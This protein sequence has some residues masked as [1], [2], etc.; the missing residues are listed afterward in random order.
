MVTQHGGVLTLHGA[1]VDTA[2]GV[3]VREWDQDYRASDAGTIAPALTARVAAAFRLPQQAP[4]E[5]TTP[6]AYP[7]YVAGLAALRRGGGG[8]AAIEAVAL[9]EQA[10]AL[11]PAAVAPR[12]VLA[13]ASAVAYDATRDVSWLTRGRDALAQ[14]ERLSPDAIPVHL[15]AGRLNEVAAAYDL[16]AQEYARAAE[17]DAN[18]A[19]AWRGLARTYQGMQGHDADA[20]RAFQT[21]IDVQPNYFAPLNDYADFHGCAATTRRPKRRR[22]RR[23]GADSLAAHANSAGCQR[24]GR[25][26]VRNANCGGPWHRRRAR[27]C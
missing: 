10:V 27:R 2:S 20:A 26:A 16:A 13:E 18:S 25:H 8:G 5:R 7:A 19:D 24:R 12:A 4:R 9:L 1:I 21:A 22:R 23:P 15:A 3:A 6:A 17:L 11:D 14:A